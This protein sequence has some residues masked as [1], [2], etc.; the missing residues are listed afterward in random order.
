MRVK[1]ILNNLLSN[2]IKYQKELPGHGGLIKISSYKENASIGIAVRDNGD[3]IRGEILPRIFDMFYR[4]HERSKGSGLGL[5]IAK[6]AAEKIKASLTVQSR[7][8]EG[9]VF[10]LILP[11]V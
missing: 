1:I 3:G 10:T 2:A 5:Y 8:S 6:D 7:F 11:A 4:G 9:S